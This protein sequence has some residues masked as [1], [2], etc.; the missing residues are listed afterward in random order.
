[1]SKRVLIISM[2]AFE[3]SELFYPRSTLIDAGVEVVVASK[4]MG[5]IRSMDGLDW[6]DPIEVDSTFGDVSAADF[7]ALL[8]PGGVANPDAMRVESQAVDLVRAF[9]KAGKPVAAICHG[10]WTLVEADVVNGKTVT[11][12]P[13]VRTDLKNAGA[14]VVDQEV[15]TDGNLITSRNPDDLPAFTNALIGALNK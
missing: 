8:I 12:Y 15:A 7:D 9:V 3:K 13:T 1:M 2:E 10:P 4:E 11:S 6:S 14:K 5:E